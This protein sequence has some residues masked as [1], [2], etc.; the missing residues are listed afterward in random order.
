LWPVN[1]LNMGGFLEAPYLD[2]ILAQPGPTRSFIEIAPSSVQLADPNYKLGLFLV[3]SAAGNF[4]LF[5]NPQANSVT[6]YGSNESMVVASDSML[7]LRGSSVAVQG[8]ITANSSFSATT[9]TDTGLTSGRCVQ[10]ST[11]GL[12]T[13]TGSSCTPVNVPLRYVG[14]VTTTTGTADSLAVTGL[15]TSNHCSAQ[16]T[17]SGAATLAEYLSISSG[18]VTLKHATGTAGTTFDLFCNLL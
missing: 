4:Q 17:N 18:S 7:T 13:T 1:L 2:G 3:N 11:G 10:A 9:I 15:T 16:A 8:P 14:T 6:M 5:M 12:L